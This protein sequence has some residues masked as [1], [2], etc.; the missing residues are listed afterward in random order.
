MNGQH[1]ALA[2]LFPR[3]KDP[4]THCV[5]DWVGPRADLGEKAKGKILCHCGESNLVRTFLGDTLHFL[6]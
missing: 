6:S 2:A 1:H 3:R 5:E 4:A